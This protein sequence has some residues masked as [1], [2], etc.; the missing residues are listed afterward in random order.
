MFGYR[1]VPKKEAILYV[2]D[3]YDSI[4]S[5]NP[6]NTPEKKMLRGSLAAEAYLMEMQGV[7]AHRDDIAKMIEHNRLAPLD[8][9]QN[10]IASATV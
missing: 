10:M 3:E 2:N 5:I 9:E 8:S 1:K 6:L 7:L 4:I